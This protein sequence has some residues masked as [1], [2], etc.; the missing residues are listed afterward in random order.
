MLLP[1]MQQPDKVWPTS[2][3]LR[4]DWKKKDAKAL[5]AIRLRLAKDVLVYAQDATTA[6]E[7]WDTL[8]DT[9]QPTGPIGIVMARRRLFRAQCPETRDVEE[10]LRQMHSWDAFIRAIDPTDLL[11]PAEGQQAKLTSAKLIARILQEDR[12]LK[13]R[14][15]DSETALIARNARDESRF[16]CFNCGRRGHKQDKCRAPP[17]SAEQRA[18]IQQSVCQSRSSPRSFS[19]RAH[20]TETTNTSASTRDD[21][22]DNSEPTPKFSDHLGG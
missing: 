12:R 22:R 11:P 1:F 2:E 20:V 13:Q 19:H 10:H 21:S 6:K 8:A 3:A 17:A 9:F 7:A 14:T 5:R 4:A 15:A 16:T 18:C